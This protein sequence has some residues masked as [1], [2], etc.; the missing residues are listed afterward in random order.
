DTTASSS[1]ESEIV[2]VHLTGYLDNPNLEFESVNYSQ[3][4]I[5]MFLTRTQNVGSESFEQ[6][7]L[8]ASAAN[9]ASM[10]F[11]RQLERNVSRFSGLDDFEL[12]TN[13]NLLSRRETDQWSVMLGRKIAPNL[14][15]RYER[16]LSTEPNQQF[17]LEYRLNRNMSIGGDVDQ[18]GYSINYRY[19]YR[20]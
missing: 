2:T 12:R 4:D 9:V 5:L 8:S 7:Q 17:G 16:T 14:Y 6:D 10:W 1:S 13:G 19:K 11:E 18:D 15:V 20:Y 3:S